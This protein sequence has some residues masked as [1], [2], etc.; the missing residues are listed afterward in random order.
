MEIF[1]PVNLVVQTKPVGSLGNVLLGIGAYLGKSFMIYQAMKETTTNF[2]QFGMWG[3]TLTAKTSD[4][5]SLSGYLFGPPEE[6]GRNKLPCVIFFH[7]NAGTVGQRFSYFAEYVTRC[8]VNLVVFG[9]RGYSKS[10]GH[11]SMGGLQKDGD[12]ILEKVFKDLGAQVNLEKVIIHGKSLGG[13][14][15]SH[16]VSQ[17]KWNGKVQGVILDTCFNSMSK[18][19]T[20]TVPALGSVADEIFANEMWDVVEAAQKFNKNVPV[21]VIGAVNDEICPY[22]H[23]VNL[24]NAMINQGRK[25]HFETFDEGGHND[26]TIING[27]KYFNTIKTFIDSLQ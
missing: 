4:G 5:I 12:A 14:V 27:Q 18:L 20:H 13:G 8:R 17:D 11:P 25:T 2:A 1:E 24:Y 16:A 19:V 15:G 6:E 9:Y 22:E 21:L 7:E 26:F 23:S 3:T 10:P